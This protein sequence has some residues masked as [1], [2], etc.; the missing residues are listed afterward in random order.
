MQ[1]HFQIVIMWA[2]V[3]PPQGYLED[4]RSFWACQHV[5]CEFQVSLVP[6][7]EPEDLLRIKQNIQEDLWNYQATNFAVGSCLL[8]HGFWVF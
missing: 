8:Q 3:F 4:K 1:N 5:T 2:E 6:S 7:L